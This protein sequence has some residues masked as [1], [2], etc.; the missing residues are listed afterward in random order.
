[1]SLIIPDRLTSLVPL[2]GML[3]SLA[4]LSDWLKSV[5]PLARPITCGLAAEAVIR[6]EEKSWLPNGWRVLPTTLPPFFRQS[7]GVLLKRQAEGIVGRQR[8]TRS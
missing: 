2:A 7:C 4:C 5:P 3:N 8:S 1:M 6:N